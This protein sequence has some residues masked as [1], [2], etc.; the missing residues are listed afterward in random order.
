MY[1]TV[2]IRCIVREVQGVLD[3]GS[4]DESKYKLAWQLNAELI[5]LTKWQYN[6]EGKKQ[7]RERLNAEKDKVWLS[8]LR[9]EPQ[10]EAVHLC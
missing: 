1:N 9:E 10:K 3:Q 6:K 7:E 8:R 4:D 5:H 2:A